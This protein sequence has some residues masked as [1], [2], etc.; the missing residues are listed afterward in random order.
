MAGRAMKSAAAKKIPSLT[1]IELLQ[2]TV[3]TGSGF[4]GPGNVRAWYARRLRAVKGPTRSHVKRKAGRDRPSVLFGTAGDWSDHAESRDRARR[5]AVQALARAP[6][7]IRP[8][9]R[10]ASTEV[11]R[12][13]G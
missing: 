7:Q 6:L 1:V 5:A 2:S 4:D 3:I 10:R 8:G 11:S 12:A 9:A 13:P